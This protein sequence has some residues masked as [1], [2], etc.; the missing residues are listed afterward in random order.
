[1]AP[2]QPD[3]SPDEARVELDD[4]RSVYEPPAAELSQPIQNQ[5]PEGIGGWLILVAIGLVLTPIRLV[6]MML[7]AYAEV[8]TSGTWDVLTTPGSGAYSPLWAPLLLGEIVINALL[9]CAGIVLIY[10]F[11]TKRR[12][13]R[14]FYI[15]VSLFSLAFI[16]VDAYSFKLVLPDDPVFDPQTARELVRAVIA[17]AVWVPYMLVSKR[18]KNTFVR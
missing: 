17:A 8:F 18:A 14:R 5:G 9:L 4:S 3:L 10:L 11:F 16:V 6:A 7:P 2:E 13:F 12:P 15:G 1:M